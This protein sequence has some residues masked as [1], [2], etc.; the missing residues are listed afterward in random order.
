MLIMEQRLLYRSDLLGRKKYSLKNQ[1]K[2]MCCRISCIYIVLTHLLANYTLNGKEAKV[3][4]GDRVVSA[5]ENEQAH[6][7]EL[8]RLEAIFCH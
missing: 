1:F 7:Y 8:T 4:R 3:L 2:C 5:G 6:Q